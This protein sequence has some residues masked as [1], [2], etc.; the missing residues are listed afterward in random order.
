MTTRNTA[1]APGTPCWVDL[2]TSDINK[3]NAFYSG[4]FGWTFTEGAPEYGGYR[5][6]LSDGHQVAGAMPNSPEFGH[7]DGWNTYISTADIDASLEAARSAGGTVVSGPDQVGDLGSMAAV[8]DPAGGAI[9]LWQPAGHIGFTKY[10]EP[11]SVT[12]NEYLSKDFAKAVPFYSAVFGWTATP[13]GDDDTFRY[14]T[15]DIDGNPVAGMMDA[16]SFLPAEVPS[17]WVVY[18]SVPDVDAATSQ[19]GELG[20]TVIRPGQDTPFGRMADVLDPTGVPFKLH[21]PNNA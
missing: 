9:A 6:I 3:A 1:F 18:F 12:W 14:S 4:L 11:G 7:P 15:G 2:F 10:N 13:V 5:S 21:G 19:V 8:I 16:S 17:H 20:G